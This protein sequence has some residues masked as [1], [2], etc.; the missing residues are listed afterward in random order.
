M[1]HLL[2]D[3]TNKLR[4]TV[5]CFGLQ[6]HSIGRSYS[7]IYSCL[8]GDTHRYS[9]TKE[10][11]CSC[12]MNCKEDVVHVLFRC[13]L[14]NDERQQFMNSLQ[15]VAPDMLFN[16]FVSMTDMNKFVFIASCLNGTILLEWL[17]V[18]TLIIDY[19]ATVHRAR[20]LMID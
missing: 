14:Y 10:I 8:N 9:R 4:V 17:P 2:A 1:S 11:K 7:Y 6:D 12:D 13:R 19:V 20:R 5:P 16:E 15:Q 18:Y 3:R